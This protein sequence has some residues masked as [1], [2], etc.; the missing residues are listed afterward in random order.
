MRF[1]EVLRT[2]T[3]FFDREGIRFAVVGGLAIH[4][5]G[6]SRF[7]KDVDLVVERSDRERVIAFA[8]SRGYE[9]L[10]VNDAFSNHAHAD[11][12]L[13]RVDILYV[14]HTTAGK[15]FAAAT[16]RP[17]VGDYEGPVASA[18]HMAMMKGLAMKNFPHRALYEREDVRILMSVP[19]VDRNAVRDYFERIGML[20]MLNGI[21]KER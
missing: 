14:D 21:D 11:P 6:G 12:D 19:G 17:I 2:F 20:E 15:M 3:D 9:T 10:H 5:W 18:E 16:V 13:G 7:T 4:V 1:D 8:E